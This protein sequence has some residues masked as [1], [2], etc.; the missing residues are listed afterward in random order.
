MRLIRMPGRQSSDAWLIVGLGNPGGEYEATRHN[1]GFRAID[2]IAGEIGA[3]ALKKKFNAL[4][5]EGRN[6]G[7]KI[8]LIKPQTFMNLSGDAVRRALDYYRAGFDRLIVIYDDVDIAPGSIR[9]RAFGG[10]GS[11]NG[12]RSIADCI[13]DGAKFPR[14][15]IGIGKQPGQM[16]LRDYVLQRFSAE[17][18]ELAEK[19]IGDAAAAA[20]AIVRDGID[21]AMNAYNPK[22]R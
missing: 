20:L 4:V 18:A 6:G 15:R 17:E 10:P 12:M 22:R 1:V 19:A 21:H 2:K 16:E 9:V 11:H 3:P 5:G 14:I 8:V 13:G 7:G